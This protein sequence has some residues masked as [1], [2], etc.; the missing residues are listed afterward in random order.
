MAQDMKSKPVMFDAE[1]TSLPPEIQEKMRRLEELEAQNA[2]LLKD[3][4]EL[5]S[6]LESRGLQSSRSGM[7]ELEQTD[8]DGFPMYRYT[9]D[10]PSSGGLCLTINGMNY[11]HGQAYTVD[12]HML[13]TMLDMVHRAWKHEE[14]IHGSNENAY[15]PQ[16][17]ATF[18]M[19]TGTRIR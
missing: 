15:R 8:S 16:V 17:N 2:D 1:G 12:R 11:F 18:N 6:K 10:L 4:D 3:K 5:K 9:I 7:V 14:T 19:R 13:S